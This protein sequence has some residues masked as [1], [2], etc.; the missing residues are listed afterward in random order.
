MKQLHHGRAKHLNLDLIKSSVIFQ[1]IDDI[2]RRIEFHPGQV[3][4]KQFM[5]L[6]QYADPPSFGTSEQF[7]LI[8]HYDPATLR[9]IERNYLDS[10]SFEVRDLLEILK[11]YSYF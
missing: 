10:D 4:K 8:R 9:Y 3:G 1:V 7:R 5:V 2:A 6:M 11:V